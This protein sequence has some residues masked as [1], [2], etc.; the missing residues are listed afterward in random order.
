MSNNKPDK[1]REKER[2]EQFASRQKASDSAFK[3]REKER[4]DQYKSRNKK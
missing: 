3:Q 1:Q 4:N 2:N